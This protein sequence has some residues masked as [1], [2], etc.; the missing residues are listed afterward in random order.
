MRD[1]SC[2]PREEKLPSLWKDLAVLG[3]WFSTAHVY[4]SLW[5]SIFE[6]R[7]KPWHGPQFMDTDL[8]I[9]FALLDQ[10]GSKEIIN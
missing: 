3:L 7:A 8:E 2:E 1:S 6:P 4:E 10:G 5:L 9:P